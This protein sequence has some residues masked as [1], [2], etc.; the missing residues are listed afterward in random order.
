MEEVAVQDVFKMASTAQKS[1]IW[2]YYLISTMKITTTHCHFTKCCY[3]NE[4]IDRKMQC[5]QK[6][7]LN[8]EKVGHLDKA[9]LNCGFDLANNL[10]Y[11]AYKHLQ[12]D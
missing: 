4:V 6:H 8:C 10:S 1:L 12:I 9:Q 3:C 7:M 11:S 5:M 2:K